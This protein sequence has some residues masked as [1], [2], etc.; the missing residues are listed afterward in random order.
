MNKSLKMKDTIDMCWY[1]KEVKYTD[2]ELEF[3]DMWRIINEL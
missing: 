1:M 3:E 2:L